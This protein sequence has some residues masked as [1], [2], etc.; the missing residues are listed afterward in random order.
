MGS[1]VEEYVQKII[2]EGVSHTKDYEKEFEEFLKFF[3]EEKNDKI[4]EENRSDEIEEKNTEE[5][6]NEEINKVDGE[7]KYL[8]AKT[9]MKRKRKTEEDVPLKILTDI[10]LRILYPIS[11]CMSKGIAMGLVKDLGYTPNAILNHGPKMLIFSENA[12]DSFVKHLHLIECYLAKNMFGK[13]TA[14]RLLDCDIEI[15][16]IKY[17]GDQQI[18]FKDLS[19]HNNKIQL[20]REE[21][22]L[23]SCASSPVTRYMKQL[24]FSSSVIKEYLVDAMEQHPDSQILHGPIDTSIFNRIPYEVEMWRSIKEYERRQKK[25]EEEITEKNEEITEHNEETQTI[26]PE[27]V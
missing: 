12:W 1:E 25:T 2:E 26:S 6:I 13:K 21:F 17:R 8:S 23:L 22:F 20:T 27:I 11:R 7:N 4:T 5:R 9:G 10:F 24:A 3:K 18:R 15:D 16:I 14:I 19:K